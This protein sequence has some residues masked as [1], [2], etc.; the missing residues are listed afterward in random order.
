MRALNLIVRFACEIAALV[1]FVW[2]GWPFVGWVVAI[3]VAVMWG[4]VVAPKATHR[5]PDPPRLLVELVIFASAIVAFYETA[6]EAVAS[7]FGVLAVASAVLVR[8]WPE[9]VV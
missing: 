6:G 7:V 4:L 1:A 9:P 2:W 5:L 8:V 3:V